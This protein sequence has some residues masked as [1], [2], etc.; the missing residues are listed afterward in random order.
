ML[1]ILVSLIVHMNETISPIVLF[2][3]NRRDRNI[4]R[5]QYF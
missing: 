5:V 3:D 1:F 4:N 2:N